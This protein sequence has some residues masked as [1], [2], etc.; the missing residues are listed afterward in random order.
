[1]GSFFSFS[2]FIINE[3]EKFLIDQY[4]F[5]PVPG[6]NNNYRSAQIPVNDFPKVCKDNGI[7]TVL[8]LNFGGLDGRHTEDQSSVSIEEEKK[9]C[10]KSQ[11][12]FLK[13]NSN[14]PS[15][16]EIMNKF[17]KRGNCLIHCAHG[18]DRTGGA[19]GGYLFTE[20]PAEDLTTTDEIWKYTTQYNKWNKILN[21]NPKDF[22]EDYYLAQA[23][24]FG[25]KDLDHAIKLAQK[26]AKN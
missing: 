24:K 2:Q 19:I 10:E 9:V 26:Y 13:M 3:S 4:N 25:V 12:L 20:K 8:R 1:M 17:L 6:G 21:D 7:T 22:K 18:A 11:I 16:Q 5:H 14:D 23:Q 15:D